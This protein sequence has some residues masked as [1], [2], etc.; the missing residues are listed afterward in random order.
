MLSGLRVV[1]VRDKNK[2][3]S[4]SVKRG[5]ADQ[6]CHLTNQKTS[7]CKFWLGDSTQK[8]LLYVEGQGPSSNT[9]CH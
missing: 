7:N 5:T 1:S 8:S 9:I 4:F 2:D 6:L 3:Q